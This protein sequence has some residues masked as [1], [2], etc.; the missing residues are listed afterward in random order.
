MKIKFLKKD[1]VDMT[2]EK[3]I[4]VEFEKCEIGKLILSS[5]CTKLFIND[6]IVKIL[7]LNPTIEDL[8][9][10]DC[11]IEEII[12]NEPITN[13]QFMH[14]RD[15]KLTKLDIQFLC[16]PLIMDVANNNIKEV[17]H[18]IPFNWD[19][20]MDGNPIIDMLK[21]YEYIQY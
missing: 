9:C 12:A 15:N 17:I 10:D 20:D 4:I 14:I 1:I 7:V 3:D 13:M 18:K 2:N 19:L 5:Y 8:N 6:S 16:I 21:P 11:G